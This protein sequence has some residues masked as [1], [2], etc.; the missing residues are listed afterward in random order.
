MKLKKSLRALASSLAITLTACSSLS[1]NP[2]TALQLGQHYGDQPPRALIDLE[3]GARRG[4]TA[5]VATCELNQSAKTSAWVKIM[6]VPGRVVFSDGVTKVPIDFNYRK[7]NGWIWKN[8]IIDRTWV[9]LDIG[10]LAT[11]FGDVPVAFDVQGQSS[12]GV[13][14]NRGLIYTRVCDDKVTPCSRLE[15]DYDCG[16]RTQTAKAGVIG[17][18]IRISGSSQKIRV[19]VA[20]AGY[21]LRAG[22]RLVI[23]SPADGWSLKH[24][25]T[26]KDVSDGQVLVTYPSVQSGPDLLSLVVFQKDEAELHGSLLIVGHPAE[27]TGIDRPHLV[28]NT[29]GTV[30][31]CIPFRANLLEIAEGEKVQ[32]L[33][34]DCIRWGK[35]KEQVCAYAFDRESGDQTYSCVKAGR[36]V[37]FP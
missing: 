36:D 12:D 33:T 25:L 15:Y 7:D 29:D 27:W 32:T 24:D 5:G 30:D 22:S 21:K 9:P 2:R 18:C 1:L 26:D 8:T 6:P 35:P 37:R 23:H 28:T 16:R 3:C 20:T 31:A 17:S 34:T 13:I 4:I 14:N 19:P 10:E 11:I